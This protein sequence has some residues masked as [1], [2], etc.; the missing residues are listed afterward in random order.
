MLCAEAATD[1]RGVKLLTSVPAYAGTP[2]HTLGCTFR[3][4]NLAMSLFGPSRE[5]TGS[6]KCRLMGRERKLL[7]LGQTDVDDQCRTS[8]RRPRPPTSPSRETDIRRCLQNWLP[9][10]SRTNFYLDRA[11]QIRSDFIRR[12]WHADKMPLTFIAI[13]KAEEFELFGCLYPLGN[14]VDGKVSRKKDY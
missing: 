13:V 2:I 11:Q 3:R 7:T 4:L 8:R 10:L 14:D 6:N 1:R 5:T 9:P 12:L